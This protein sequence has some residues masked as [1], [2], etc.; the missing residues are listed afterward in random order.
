MAVP[1]TNGT[2]LLNLL[3]SL[4][5]THV[6]EYYLIAHCQKNILHLLNSTVSRR[7]ATRDMIAGIG[8][9]YPFINWVPKTVLP[10]S[11]LIPY[12]TKEQT[13]TKKEILI[14]WTCE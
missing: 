5:K 6:K 1:P 2:Q 7:K 14:K 13:K 8:H 12:L 3:R 4:V 9:F 10:I 11:T